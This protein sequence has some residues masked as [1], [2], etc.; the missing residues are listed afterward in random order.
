MNVNPLNDKD[1]KW[2]V[3]FISAGS[4]KKLL[5]KLFRVKRGKLVVGGPIATRE[6]RKP[7]IWSSPKLK[8]P[9]SV[10]AG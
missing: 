1:I 3:M 4:A 10:L 6:F 5:W 2:A 9:A 8:S 7:I